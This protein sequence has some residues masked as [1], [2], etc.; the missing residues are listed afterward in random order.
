MRAGPSCSSS[1]AAGTS[2]ASAAVTR[3]RKHPVTKTTGKKAR[4]WSVV[5]TDAVLVSVLCA[6]KY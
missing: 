4:Q 1:S 6:V 5:L 3:K 2:A